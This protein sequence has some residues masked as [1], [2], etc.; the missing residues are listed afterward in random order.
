M[1]TIDPH[2]LSLLGFSIQGDL[3]PLT[4]YTNKNGKQVWFPRASPL[5]PPSAQQQQMRDFFRLCA[6]AWASMTQEQRNVWKR[7][8]D[9]GHARITGYNL[10]TWY[11]RTQDGA[12]IRTIARQAGE[13]SPV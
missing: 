4:T 6:S 7:I 8:A 9:N 5:N 12:T 13:T 3:G 10:F 2:V 1:A 11:Q